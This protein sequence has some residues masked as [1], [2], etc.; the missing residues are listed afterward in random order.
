[1]RIHRV[2]SSF[3]PPVRAALLQQKY[4]LSHAF[5]SLFSTDPS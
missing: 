2:G 3:S 4:I 5:T 1:V